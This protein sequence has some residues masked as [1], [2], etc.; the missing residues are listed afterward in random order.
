MGDPIAN[1]IF[2]SDFTKEGMNN[3]ISSL[4]NG[5]LGWDEFTPPPPPPPPPNDKRDKKFDQ[6]S[7]GTY[8]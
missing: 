6:F 8:F 5:A 7:F 3:I 4:K 1:S 2:L